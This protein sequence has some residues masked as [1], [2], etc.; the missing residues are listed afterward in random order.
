MSSLV[1]YI[2]LSNNRFTIHFDKTFT[3]FKQGETFI[4][5]KSDEH[6]KQTIVSVFEKLIDK[7]NLTLNHSLWYKQS[8]DECITYYNLNL[9]KSVFLNDYINQHNIKFKTN[10]IM[11]H[12]KAILKKDYIL[13]KFVFGEI[14]KVF[15][16]I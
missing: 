15:F 2:D 14:T 3:Y 6:F 1:F 10:V 4:T 12:L 11:N 9:R 16:V 13:S 5:K 8:C 7:L